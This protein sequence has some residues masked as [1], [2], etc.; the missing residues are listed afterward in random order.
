[1]KLVL[2]TAV[3]IFVPYWALAIAGTTLVSAFAAWKVIGDPQLRF[4]KALLVS[5]LVTISEVGLPVMGLA[6]FGALVR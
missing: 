2:L 1:M 6:I 3:W 4:G 5:V